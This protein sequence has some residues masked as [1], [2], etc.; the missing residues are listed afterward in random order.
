MRSMTQRLVCVMVALLS[1]PVMGQAQL[2]YSQNFNENPG[3]EWSERDTQDLDTVG[4]FLGPFGGM[5]EDPGH[6]PMNATL[7]VTNDGERGLFALK[8]DLILFDNWDRSNDEFQVKIRGYTAF[9]SSFQSLGTSSLYRRS[10]RWLDRYEDLGYGPEPELVI[11]DIL[12]PFYV[13]QPTETIE[14]LADYGESSMGKGW[15]IDNVQIIAYQGSSSM[16]DGLTVSW[17]DGIAGNS[18]LDQLTSGVV[19]VQSH[20][21]QVAWLP[22]DAALQSSMGIDN[23]AWHTEGGIVIPTTGSWKFRVTS[24][25]DA[26]LTIDDET[27][28]SSPGGP[29][30]VRKIATAA[31]S[32]GTHV[33]DMK[34]KNVSGTASLV[35]EWMG[36]GQSYWSVVPPSAFKPIMSSNI[37]ITDVTDASGLGALTNRFAMMQGWNDLN[38]DGYPDMI[39]GGYPAPVLFGDSTGTF[40][41]SQQFQ[42]L[43]YQIA[44]ADVDNDGDID[45]LS[46]FRGLQENDGGVLT[47]RGF[48]G[49]P[50]TYNFSIAAPDLNSDGRS[51]LA[52]TLNWS[53]MIAVNQATDS[54][55][56][57]Y[58]IS[59]LT[60]LFSDFTRRWYFANY[61]DADFNND[62]AADLFVSSGY[63]GAGL[64]L[65]N[66][67]G[68]ALTTLNGLSTGWFSL[69]SNSAVADIENDGDLDMFYGGD[70][71]GRSNSMLLNDGSATLTS[72]PSTIPDMA[73]R[74]WN[75]ASFGDFDNDGD[76]DLLVRSLFGSRVE[77]RLNNG[78]GTFAAGQRID[79]TKQYP[80]D[81]AFVDYD[82][83]GDL[84]ISIVSYTGVSLYRNDTN[85]H[86][87][88]KVRIVGSGDGA[89]NVAGVGTRVE[90]LDAHTR[91][92]LARRD[93]TSTNGSGAGPFWLHFGGVD[94]TGS[95]I[96]RVHFLS[97]VREVAVVPSQATTQIGSTTIDQ[98]LTIEESGGRGR[99]VTQWKETDQR[100]TIRAALKAEA[101]RRGLDDQV[102]ALREANH[103]TIRN[104]L[105]LLG[106]RNI[107]DAL[108]D[109]AEVLSDLNRD[110]RRNKG[111]SGSRSGTR[112]NSRA[113]VNRP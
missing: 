57:R 15:A 43:Y 89:T 31:L 51:D 19:Q 88:L 105:Q 63:A 8:F 39:V 47:S 36:P 79:G 71:L 98:M 44:M 2:P 1:S 66:D 29:G 46:A 7:G 22:T 95:Y 11:R 96:V 32:A 35:L 12:I 30:D 81:A 3:A 75:G 16:E 77:L 62:A 106:A 52:A 34:S 84:D 101:I 68:Y 73:D 83:D 49:L 69:Y 109:N 74:M 23:F 87:Y 4:R 113:G 28:L 60:S 91:R 56:I 104:L 86:R 59:S 108:G 94:P 25:D 33:F 5:D 9:R 24:T 112:G 13:W 110:P 64:L 90:L 40:A 76:Q 45:L 61:I 18:S 92:F 42:W 14:F 41:V 26:T 107:R 54:T 93:I 103:L 6:Y 21:P 20:E 67:Q 100:G 70:Y 97:G 85:G 37:A 53:P 99:R 10:T 48:P 50:I 111:R 72:S 38:G 82:N 78:D 65:S 17:I 27:I 102:V 80:F 55:T 58:D